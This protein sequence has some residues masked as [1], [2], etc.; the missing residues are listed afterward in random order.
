MNTETPK[1]QL[2]PSSDFLNKSNT[3]LTEEDLRRVSGG[4]TCCA[5]AHLA[6]GGMTIRK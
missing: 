5:G 2:K 3:E 4:L 6:M 1:E